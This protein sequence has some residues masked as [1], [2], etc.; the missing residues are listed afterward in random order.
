MNEVLQFA[1]LGLGQGAIIAGVAIS[2][3]LF[4]RGSGV[5]NLAAGAIAMVTG[6]C[7]W[8]LQSG[9]FGTTFGTVPAL[10]ISFLVAVA[11]GLIMEFGA[12]RPLRTAP[13]LAK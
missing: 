8:A 9:Q 2:L 4:Y 5:I 10:A 6:Y 13:P 1:V 3:V 12:F 11:Q 7:F